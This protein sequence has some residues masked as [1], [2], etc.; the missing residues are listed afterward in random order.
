MKVSLQHLSVKPILA[1]LE[2]LVY[3][4]ASP[5]VLANY[6]SVIKAKFILYDLLYHVCENVKKI[7][8]EIC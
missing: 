8:F 1:F 6:V 7:F 3:N 2:C 4:K 5:A